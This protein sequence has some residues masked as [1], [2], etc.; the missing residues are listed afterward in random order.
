VA[1]G[2]RLN[3][4]DARVPFGD[5]PGGFLHG[6]RLPRG[7]EELLRQEPDGVLGDVFV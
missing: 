4:V 6:P 7:S 2:L 5:L 1:E 3:L